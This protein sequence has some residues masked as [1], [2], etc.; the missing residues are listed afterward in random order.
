MTM[1]SGRYPMWDWT[2]RLATNAAPIS[3]AWSRYGTKNGK[4]TCGF[5]ASSSMNGP[6]AVRAT[7]TPCRRAEPTSVAQAAP[8]VTSESGASR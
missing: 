5:Q 8:P 4:A 7:A 3:H 6:V 1:T 2:R